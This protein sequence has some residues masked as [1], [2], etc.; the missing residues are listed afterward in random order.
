MTSTNL[1]ASFAVAVVT[2]VV[3][4]VVVPRGRLPLWM[5]PVATTTAVLLGAIVA[6]VAGIG[7]GRTTVGELVVEA[8]FGC[9][10]VVL[11][12]A[13]ADRKSSG[14]RDHL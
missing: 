5:T 12:A 4:I 6:W 1:L 13:A 8:I 10:A 14:P 9:C 2:A 3:G 7:G 11:V